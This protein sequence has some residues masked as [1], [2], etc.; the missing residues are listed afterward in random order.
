MKIGSSAAPNK[1]CPSLSLVVASEF[2]DLFIHRRV[3]SS[4]AALSNIVILLLPGHK[5][6]QALSNVAANLLLAFPRHG[7]WNA[8]KYRAG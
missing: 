7:T 6:A 5:R 4:L 8:R 1:L 3:D 2:V